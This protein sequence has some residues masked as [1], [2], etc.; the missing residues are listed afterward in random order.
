MMML[1]WLYSIGI[2]VA[3]LLITYNLGSENMD[4]RNV[5]GRQFATQQAVVGIYALA[6]PIVLACFMF[7]VW[8]EIQEKKI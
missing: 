6:W 1:L 8:W 4:C 7:I 5:S 3:G 2:P